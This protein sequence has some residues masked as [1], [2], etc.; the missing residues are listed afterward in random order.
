MGIDGGIPALDGTTGRVEFVRRYN[1]LRSALKRYES[2]IEFNR[3]SAGRSASGRRELAKR[4]KL[5]SAAL[6]R[7]KYY[8]PLYALEGEDT[9][10]DEDRTGAASTLSRGGIPFHWIEPGA[11]LESRR[12]K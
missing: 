9:V 2:D 1:Q 8:Y 12:S 7:F 11:V 4:E 5:L 6:S 10:G 3:A